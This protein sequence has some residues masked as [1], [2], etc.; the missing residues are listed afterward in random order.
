VALGPAGCPKRS[1][2]LVFWS[3]GPRS[4]RIFTTTGAKI[5]R[6]T[7]TAMKTSPA[8]ATLSCLKRRQKSW[9]GD[10]AAISARSSPPPP[11]ARAVS[12]WT[13]TSTMLT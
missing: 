4:P 9:S 2:A 3:L 11:A 1:S 5:A 8:S 13:V 12:S 7:R 10:F 6:M